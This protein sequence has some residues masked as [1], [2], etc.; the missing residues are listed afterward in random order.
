MNIA[1]TSHNQEIGYEWLKSAEGEH[2][3]VASFAR[4][5]LQLMSIG[6]TNDLLVASQKAAIDEINH[7]KI[8]FELANI[9]T[10]FVF[11]PGPLDVAGS[12]RSL[13]LNDVIQSVIQEGCIEET[14]AAMKAKIGSQYADDPVVKAALSKIAIEETSHAQLAWNTIKWAIQRYPKITSLVEDTFQYWLKRH[15]LQESFEI[16]RKP[17]FCEDTEKVKTFRNYGLLGKND[18][19][20]TTK[21][22][23]TEI[24]EPVIRSGF[25]NVGLISKK[26]AALSFK[27]L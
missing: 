2:A 18:V 16:P 13:D 7:A 1:N 24:V 23:I 26:I 20:K 19:D 15:Q 11:S 25:E 22:G 14:L 10:G 12:L 3:S 4:H 17:L 8:S 21:K 27:N 6:S 5:T 9:F